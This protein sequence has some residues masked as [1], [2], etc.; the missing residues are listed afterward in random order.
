MFHSIFVRLFL[1]VYLSSCLIRSNGEERFSPV[2]EDNTQSIKNID[3]E[4]LQAM[5]ER[6]KP[7]DIILTSVD[8]DESDLEDGEGKE[9]INLDGPPPKQFFHLHHMKSGGTSLSSHIA[10]GLN[11]LQKSMTSGYISR[12]RLSECS[13]SSYHRC[14]D[15]PDATCNSSIDS[16][17]TMTYCAPLFI[18]SQF[19]WDDA[20]AV[21]IMRDPIDRVWS[22]FRFQTKSCFRCTDLTQ[23]YADI[24]KNETEGK[25][26]GGVCL[27]QLQNHITRNMQSKPTE[28]YAS[29]EER[30][31]DAIHNIQTRFTLVGL[32]SNLDDTLE[33]LSYTFPWM[34]ASVP[35]SETECQFPKAN[36]SPRNNH[37]LQDSFGR[38]KHWDLPDTP[39]EETRKAIEEHNQLDI[40][41]YEVALEHFQ[42]QWEAYKWL[43]DVQ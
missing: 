14:V 26:G 15:D 37:C 33:M 16:A 18:T 43:Q 23:I 1:F 6:I 13:S 32:L 38:W 36:T 8:E 34:A 3:Q 28:E 40:K 31:E 9:M 11:R 29:E 20:D 21:T 39:D 35:D 2:F 25:Y 10:C 42:V 27:E 4:V 22:M 7:R 41:L 30:L 24:D 12:Y 17:A 19:H 5:A